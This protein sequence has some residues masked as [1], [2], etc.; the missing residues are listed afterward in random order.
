MP[1]QTNENQRQQFLVFGIL[2]IVF[3]RSPWTGDV[4]VARETQTQKNTDI[5]QCPWWDSYASSCKISP[6]AGYFTISLNRI[7][8]PVSF[9]SITRSGETIIF[10]CITGSVRS[11]FEVYFY[12]GANSHSHWRAFKPALSLSLTH[13]SVRVL[14]ST[15]LRPR[16]HC[17]LL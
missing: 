9:Y 4:H 14:G 12:P 5:H 7:F 17:D 10:W 6:Y 2:F 13:I 15:R 11:P 16:G 3:G 1:L 8:I